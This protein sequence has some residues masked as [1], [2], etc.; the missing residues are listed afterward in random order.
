MGR[1]KTT[2]EDVTYNQMSLLSSRLPGWLHAKAKTVA[3][4]KGLTLHAYLEIIVKRAIDEY[5]KRGF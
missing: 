1:L 2:A 5:D 4:K 3:S